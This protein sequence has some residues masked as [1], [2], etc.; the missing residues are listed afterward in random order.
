MQSGVFSVGGGQPEL[1]CAIVG[2]DDVSDGD[3]GCANRRVISRSALRCAQFGRADEDT[4]VPVDATCRIN[5]AGRKLKGDDLV[6]R[7][8]SEFREPSGGR[9]HAVPFRASVIGLG[10][11]PP[12]KDFRRFQHSLRLLLRELVS[13]PAAA[14]RQARTAGGPENLPAMHGWWVGQGLSVV[15]H[16][17]L[18]AWVGERGK[19]ARAGPVRSDII[20]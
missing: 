11:R 6:R 2:C 1:Y 5:V 17:R 14:R 13:G 8:D 20:L 7:T 18:L 12:C 4:A 9:A 19:R 3:R 15:R 10:V 16:S